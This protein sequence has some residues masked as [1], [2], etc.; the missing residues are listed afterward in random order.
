M[1]VCATPV[2]CSAAET[3]SSPSASTAKV[4]RMRAA[5]A[6]IGGIPVNAKRPR[7]RQVSAVSRSPCKTWI[8]MAVWPS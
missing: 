8:A 5:P 2:V 6:T 1:I 4:T 7:L 3:V